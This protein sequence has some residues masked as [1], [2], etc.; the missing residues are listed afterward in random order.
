[1]PPPK[2][3]LESKDESLVKLC[4]RSLVLWIAI[5]VAGVEP[6][7]LDDLVD[8]LEIYCNPQ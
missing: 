1:M 8:R 7:E 2:G 3:S 5:N 6:F 4:P